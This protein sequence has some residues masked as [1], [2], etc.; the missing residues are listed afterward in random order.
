MSTQTVANNL[1]KMCSAGKFMDAMSLY[2]PDI[3]S[4]EPFAPPDNRVKQRGWRQ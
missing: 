3:V 2:S 4:V 1:V